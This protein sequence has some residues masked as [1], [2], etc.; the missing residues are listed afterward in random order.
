MKCQR[1]RAE[2]CIDQSVGSG[3]QRTVKGTRKR[4]QTVP[5]IKGSPFKEDK[6]MGNRMNRKIVNDLGNIITQKWTGQASPKNNIAEDDK[7]SS[8]LPPSKHIDL[9]QQRLHLI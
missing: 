8:H 7:Y 1:M 4:R 2:Y 3:D 6:Y 5:D 9:S